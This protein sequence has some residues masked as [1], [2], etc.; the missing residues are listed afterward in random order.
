MLNKIINKLLF[1]RAMLGLCLKCCF[2]TF[3]V[4]C[5]ESATSSDSSEQK[6]YLWKVSDE[7][8]S[9]WLLGSIHVA[10]ASFY[11]LAPVID[12]AFSTASELAVETLVDEDEYQWLLYKYGLLPTGTLRDV[13][14]TDLW[15][16]LDSLCMAWNLDVLTF[17]RRRPWVVA[18]TIS[19]YAYI[20]AGLKGE[21]GIEYVFKSNAAKSGKPIVA[22]ETAEEQIAAFGGTTDSVGVF[23]LKSTMRELSGIESLIE[24]LIRA[25]KSG[26]DELL[27][28]LLNE[29]NTEGYSPLELQYLEEMNDR[30]LVKRNAKMA[31]SIATFLRDDRN[32][33]VVVG[34]AHLAF[35]QN[36]VIE[37]LRNRG[38]VVERF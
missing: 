24:N 37:I 11:P 33:F 27:N 4:A 17:E 14:P 21:Y 19:S 29:N 18:T 20:R 10:D 23:Y 28:R 31:D 13:L 15:N 5:S 16:S 30:L 1:S 32:V 3:L 38:F 7:N 8:S 6:H 36:N 34:T 35:D 26:D 9:V 25:W 2:A 22:L 12:S